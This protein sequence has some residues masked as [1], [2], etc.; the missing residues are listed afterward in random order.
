MSGGGKLKSA[1]ASLK[2]PAALQMSRLPW[3][4]LT[5]P[6]RVTT[7]LKPLVSVWSTDFAKAEFFL[8]EQPPPR[9]DGMTKSLMLFTM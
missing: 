6:V 2:P 3:N 4:D 1:R 7:V 8:D 5:S 9:F